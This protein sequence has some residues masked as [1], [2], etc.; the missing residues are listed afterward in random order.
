M[1]TPVTTK[2]H[3]LPP[4]PSNG[5]TLI[6]MFV[7]I[8]IITIISAVALMSGGRFDSSVFL[9]DTAYEVSLAIREAQS[10]GI[11]VRGET[12]F[13]GIFRTGY[14]VNFNTGANSEFKLFA[15][16]FL[17]NSDTGDGKFTSDE[18]VINTYRLKKG[19]T[20]SR[21]CAK[22]SANNTKCSDDSGGISE[23]SV[24]FTRPNPE[25]VIKSGTSSFCN[26][27]GCESADIT[28]SHPNGQK[29]KVVVYN[30]GQISVQSAQ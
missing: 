13:A 5:F 16:K 30:T 11:N 7:V 15:D 12:S 22:K 18:P 17:T 9:T 29:K 19:I 8:S 20:I 28:L 24:V 2:P 4:K 23:L 26:P 14:G 1:S 3:P 25:P 21:I 6:E 27:D 10:Y